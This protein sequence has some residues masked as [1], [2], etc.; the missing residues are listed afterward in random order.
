MVK[1]VTIQFSQTTKKHDQ[2]FVKLVLEKMLN[3]ITAIPEVCVI[4]SDNCGL[5]YKSA[6]HFDD[7]QYISN[8]IAVPVIRVFSIAGHGKGEVD[9]VGGTTK[10]AIRRY[11]GTGGSILDAAEGVAFI[12]QKFS[13]KTNPT[14]VVQQLHINELEESTKE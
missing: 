13:Q 7:L 6:Q 2:P 11:V 3:T 1:K 8:K 4:E 5:Q 10:C 14:Y 12:S 9:H